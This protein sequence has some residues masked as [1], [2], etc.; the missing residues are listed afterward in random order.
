MA[1][2]TQV[3]RTLGPVRLLVIAGLAAGVV[4]AFAW[5]VNTV[6]EPEYALLYG[7]LEAG[8]SAEIVSV[9]ES[10]GVP[11]RLANE[12]AT[13]LVPRDKTAR[14]RLQLAERGLPSGGS[15]GYE[16]FDEGDGFGATRFTQNISLVR[17]LE[18]ELART[19]RSLDLVK[20]ARVHLVLP[21]RELFQR[22]KREPTASIFLQMKGS[23][24]LNSSQVSAVQN[25]VASAVPE[26][27]PERISIVDGKGTLLSQ[28]SGDS[29]AAVTVRADERRQA[30]ERNLVQTIESLVEKTVG[31]GKVRAQVF[32][33][34]DF[35]RINSSEEIY[36]PD[37]QVVRS[38]QSV[39]QSASDKEG[40]PEGT[41]GIV[42]N[43]PDTGAA[44]GSQQNRSSA[45]SRSEETVNYEISKKI[46]NHVRETGNIRRLSVA[47][48]VDG[49]YSDDGTGQTVY[50]PRPEDEL[51]LIAKLVRGAI[52]FDDSRGDTVEVINMQFVQPELAEAEKEFEFMG[53]GKSDILN[54][55]ELV[56]VLILGLLV[57][58]L[59]VRPLIKRTLDVV[60]TAG[61]TPVLA[62]ATVSQPALTGPAQF[63]DGMPLPNVSDIP[64]VSGA[65]METMVNLAQV[66]GK[67]KASSVNQVGDFVTNHPDESLSIIRNWLHSDT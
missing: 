22:E 46:V 3:L 2:A 57:I 63:P 45:E 61:G 65:A 12:G 48:L 20:N 29:P 26:L 54:L 5:M 67:V 4:A 1:D 41:V 38:T 13:V 8:E 10:S 64:E 59:V 56:G 51:Q 28:G 11:Y 34:M 25:L 58:L 66:E 55:A 9:L 32:A 30:L 50:S 44:A 33:D 62:D 27:Q 16:I 36:D 53:F 23:R 42:P 47:V 35:D 21:K 31:A 49:R 40:E 37:G 24:R 18:G 7:D 52:G 14:L 6:T 39:Q 17:A 19:I 15:I 43:L 60:P